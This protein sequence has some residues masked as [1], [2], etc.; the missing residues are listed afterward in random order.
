[1][2]VSLALAKTFAA[3]EPHGT[4]T[5][6]SATFGGA[7]SPDVRVTEELYGASAEDML[8][9]LRSTP[10]EA[11]SVLLIAH[12][13][14]VT[15]LVTALASSSPLLAQVEAKFPTAAIAV[16]T[17]SGSWADLAPGSAALTA[18]KIPRG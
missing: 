17:Y 13:P 15:D 8:A 6:Q 10:E 1:M 14:G 9:V 16:L 2:T 11:D 7:S 4:A 3:T 18:F 12:E 5:W